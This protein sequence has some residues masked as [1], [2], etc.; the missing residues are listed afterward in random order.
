LMEYYCS[1]DVKIAGKVFELG[2]KS[3]NLA[4]DEH[5]PNYVMQY[6]DFL[7]TTNDENNAR[8]LFERALS[9][10]PPI[11]SRAIWAKL[12]EYEGQYGD[13]GTLIKNEKRMSEVY[14]EDET[15][16]LKL[17]HV[18]NHWGYL[19]IEYI[20]EIELGINVQVF[21]I[22]SAQKNSVIQTFTTTQNSL[23]NQSGDKDKTDILESVHPERY[24]RPDFSKWAPV[25]LEAT[26]RPA[27]SAINSPTISQDT[28]MT[29]ASEIIQSQIENDMQQQLTVLVPEKIFRFIQ[30][31]PPAHAYDGQHLPVEDVIELFRQVPSIQL[32]LVPPPLFPVSL[33]SQLKQQQQQQ[34]Q[35]TQFAERNTTFGND[36]FRGNYHYENNRE[37]WDRDRERRGRGRVR[38]LKI[39]FWEIIDLK[40]GS[41]FRGGGAKRKGS[42]YSDEDDSGKTI[43]HLVSLKLTILQDLDIV[44]I[45]HE[46]SRDITRR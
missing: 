38:Y 2:I 12:L 1:K 39:Q 19:D 23:Q 20:A 32:P 22:I 3:I 41:K 10:I 28:L 45:D 9:S 34:Q 31:L 4:E 30:A 25:K 43:T 40:K 46:I 42:N 26:Q 11:R 15:N 44:M 24:Q 14:P 36:R 13:L 21:T 35:L 16:V 27:L 33:N 18:A 29:Q 6:L 5:A 37:D 17:K 8:A 7:I